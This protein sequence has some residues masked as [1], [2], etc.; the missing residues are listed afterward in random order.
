LKLNLKQH[1]LVLCLAFIDPLVCVAGETSGDARA[2][3]RWEGIP[4]ESTS[5][6]RPEGGE[7]EAAAQT[8]AYL[9]TVAITPDDVDASRMAGRHQDGIKR[10]PDRPYGLEEYQKHI[11]RWLWTIAVAA[12]LLVLV[13]AYVLRQQ[14]RSQKRLLSLH[15]ELNRSRDD[16]QATI[17]AIPDLLFRLSLDGRCLDCYSPDDRF[18]DLRRSD[19]IGKT[20][21]EVFPPHVAELWMQAIQD[22]N[23]NRK[24]P[25]V[26]YAH[27]LPG[28]TRWFDVSIARHETGA[29][30]P[31]SFIATVRDI[32]EQVRLKTALLQRAQLQEQVA[33]VAEAVPGFLFTLQVAPDGRARYPFASAGVETLFGL[34]PDEIRD[35]AAVLRARYH[36]EDLPREMACIQESARTLEPLRLEMRVQHPERGLLWIEVRSQPHRH[37]DGTV[38]WHGLMIDI[39]ER[40][41][42]VAA[43][44]ESE[45]RYH[46]NSSLLQSIFDSPNTVAVYALDREY[47]YLAFNGRH[48][49]NAKRKWH[50]DIALGM[51][52][53]DVVDTDA[54]RE[55]CRQGF[56]QVL[57]GR[58]FS[59]ES[60]EP[61]VKDGGTV[62]EYNENHGAPIRDDNGEIIGLTIFAV[63]ITARKHMEAAL[64]ESEARY[65]NSTNL[66]QSIFD[67]PN[68][69][70]VYALD[71][72]YRFL[73]FNSKFREAAKR[74]WGANVSV[75]MS[76]LDAINTDET[77]EFVRH[78]CDEVL[79]GRS[80]R[81]ETKETI[82]RD[83]VPEPEHHENYGSPTYNESGEITGMTVF[84]A[85][86]TERKRGEAALAAREREFRTLAENSPDCISRYDR[87]GRV[88]YINPQLARWSGVTQGEAIGKTVGGLLPPG[89]T[90]SA[91]L[92]AFTSTLQTG[93]GRELELAVDL[94]GK[95]SGCYQIRFVAEHDEHGDTTGVLAIGH[96]IG[97]LKQKE[98]ELEASRDT[99][100]RLAAH[101]N[102]AREE[103]RK[104]IARE[105]HDHLGQ[106]L[107][108]QRLGIATLKYRFV[109]SHPELEEHCQHL[110]SITDQTIQSVRDIATILRPS[111][112]D[113]GIVPALE[114]LCN[115]FS[116]RSGLVCEIVVDGSR[117]LDLTEEQ[118]LAVF[119]IVQESLTNVARH[120]KAT[121]VRVFVERSDSAF[122]LRISD[123]GQGFDPAH[124]SS[125][126]FGL[127]GIRERAMMIGG[128]T[129]FRS[130]RL[131]GT[132]VEVT[133]PHIPKQTTNS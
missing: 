98:R 132:T 87:H 116:K 126:S 16:L 36:P 100:R 37:S 97:D 23:S 56:D 78:A 70:A 65:R 115:D 113:M 7:A 57:A 3:R 22:A 44:E 81:L 24:S 75:G 68:S 50:K 77:R 25:H 43:L 93:I 129:T 71:R 29:E 33:A 110:M 26:Q 122:V 112:L 103:E 21:A 108:A 34:R 8:A 124:V 101:S 5:T 82:I 11:L 117:A 79:G 2:D 127:L 109:A 114:W 73:A 41:R 133:I 90:A 131:E 6:T 63:N 49:E 17:D 74:L 38:E 12:L 130:V 72:E 107:T 96:D 31:P 80:F 19:L 4:G 84:S 83:G 53:L 40:K 20:L 106:M 92:E 120:A 69:V 15:A 85:N 13:T 89:N 60:E 62:S 45:A 94:P 52:M 66:L 1:L 86:I 46:R 88:L 51:S 30:E 27:D 55:F 18:L 121:R 102:L 61:V 128:R 64:K 28:G 125:G 123:D 48:R 9:N 47:R 54:H 91:Y 42:L 105:I 59:L 14:W 99:L 39:T 119:R 76:L 95:R 67:S 104:H 35:A 10:E 111:S 118:S 32:T 58:S